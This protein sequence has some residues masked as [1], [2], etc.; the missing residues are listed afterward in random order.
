MIK[1]EKVSFE[2]FEKDVI[3]LY[4]LFTKEYIEEIYNNIKLP[5]RSTAGSA[6]YDFFAPFDTTL[7]FEDGDSAKS[8][9]VI[10]TGI[11]FIV[12]NNENVFLNILPRSGMGF[13]YG[14]NLANTC[15]I[16]DS[17]YFLSENEGHIMVKLGTKFAAAP[18]I[19]GKAFVQGIILPYY[20]VDNEENVKE[21]R[22]GGFGSTDANKV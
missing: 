3:S 5:R 22:N 20:T 11:R 4:P 8:Y 19:R 7:L 15:G 1:F 2:Q 9:R 12:D 14:T 18:I 16:I 10:P 13:K 21:T 17:D 6:G